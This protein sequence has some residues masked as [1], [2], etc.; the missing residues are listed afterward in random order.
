MRLRM[1]NVKPIKIHLD[2][3]FKLSSSLCSSNDEENEYIS[4][5]PYTNVVGSLM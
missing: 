1:N 3:H 4:R 2:S 5:V